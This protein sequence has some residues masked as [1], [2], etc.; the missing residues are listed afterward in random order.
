MKFLDKHSNTLTKFATVLS[1]IVEVAYAIGALALA[2]AL[3]LLIV[4]PSAK[5]PLFAPGEE[6]TIRGFTL[7]C[8]SPDGSVDRTA[9][10]LV[11]L[12]GALTM[13]LMWWVFRNAYLI[14]RTTQGLTK[15]SKGATPFQK[16]NVRMLREIGIAFF[17][18]TAVRFLISAVAVAVIGPARAEVSMELGEAIIGILMLCLSQCFDQ[19]VQM[20]QDVDGLV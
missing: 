19:G 9:F 3:V 8:G 18:M 7:V 14:L 11:L 17:A 1:K 10:G 2:A 16:D 15:F 4:Y 13:I 5:L 6:F 12:D 20:Q